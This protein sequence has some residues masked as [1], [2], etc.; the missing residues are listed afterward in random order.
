MKIAMVNG[1]PKLGKS[2]SGFLLKTLES[3]INAE[4][5][6]IHYKM[7]KAPLTAEQY[8]ELC[9]MDMLV[10]AFPLYIDGIPSHLF[11]MLIELEKHMKTERK[12]DIY[13]YAMVNNGFFEGKQTHIAI[14]ILQNWC[15]RA[16]LQFGQ[17]IGHGAGEMLGMNDSIPL[18]RGPLKNLGMAIN[19]LANS[20]NTKA[21]GETILV[22]PNFPRFAWQ[23]AGTHFFWRTTAKKNGL[24]KKD[25][26]RQL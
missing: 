14:E 15:L 19:S 23:F 7:H 16:G 9:Q 4:S 10:F 3:L 2:N 8:L 18:G 26:L 13:V 11:R 12:G 20:I 22:S 6:I 5:E 21:E 17:A 1:S 24:K 25:L